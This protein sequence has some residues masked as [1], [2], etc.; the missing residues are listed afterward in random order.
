MSICF[1]GNNSF[2]G[3]TSFLSNFDEILHGT[4]GDHILID[5]AWEIMGVVIDSKSKFWTDF[6]GEIGLE[7]Q[8]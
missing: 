5:C 8:S 4:L 7:P 1:F 6:G 2:F 3:D